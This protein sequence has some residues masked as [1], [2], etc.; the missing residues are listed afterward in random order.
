MCAEHE[1]RITELETDNAD[2]R[3]DLVDLRH[4]VVLAHGL[5]DDFVDRPADA[6]APRTASS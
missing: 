3:G 5:L 2:L 1:Q 6:A 4:V